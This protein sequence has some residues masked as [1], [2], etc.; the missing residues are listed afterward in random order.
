MWSLAYYF[1]ILGCIYGG[2]AGRLPEIQLAVNASDFDLGVALLSS[3]IGAFSAIFIS[4]FVIR[5]VSSKTAVIATTIGYA[6]IVPL[7]GFVSTLPHLCLA[8]F[9]SGA[10]AAVLDVAIN[11]QAVRQEQRKGAPCISRLH[12]IYSIGLVGGGVLGSLLSALPLYF[13]LTLT[14]SIVISGAFVFKAG[15]LDEDEKEM[16]GSKKKG[17]LFDFS[18]EIKLLAVVLFAAALC[19]GA[20][21]EWCA[22]YLRQELQVPVWTAPLGVSAFSCGMVLGRISGDWCRARFHYSTLLLAGTTT[23][24]VGLFLLTLTTSLT[25]ALL[26]ATLCGV[27]LSVL[28]P[29]AYAAAGN[30]K[31]GERT[32]DA[33]AQL[34]AVGY[35]AVLLGPALIG[36]VSEYLGLRGAFAVLPVLLLAGTVSGWGL[37]RRSISD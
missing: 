9:M 30:T 12:A 26:A 36:G 4:P 3:S 11:M 10:V 13:H 27:G 37:R 1:F 17:S 28:V 6:G 22:K 33:L 7:L 23:T 21:V 31:A 20:L 15:L 16:S 18:P 2:W 14:S 32:E 35:S 29:I 24:A 19:E 8:L 5:R 25:I 34:T